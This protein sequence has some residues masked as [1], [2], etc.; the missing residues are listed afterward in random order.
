MRFI[1][2][3]LLFT[4]F[5]LAQSG[6]DTQVMALINDARARGV[7]CRGGGGGTRLGPLRYDATLARAARVHAYNM[8][9]RRFV[10]HFYQGVGPRARVWQAGYRYLRM[11]EVIFLG[12]NSDPARAVRW[13][14]RSPPH[15]R[16]IMNP[17]YRE[18][19]PALYRNAWVV[20]MAQP[21]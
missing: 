20:E 17:Y 7:S 13:W 12:R 21:R 10:A 16:A 8:G 1:L 6:L 5:S 19:G 15:C 3:L 4:P 11:S 14:L 9:T 18:F 2:I